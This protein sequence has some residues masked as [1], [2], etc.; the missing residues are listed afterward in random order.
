MLYR[1]SPAFFVARTRG[2]TLIEVLVALV[3]LSIGVIGLAALQAQALQLN[4]GAYMRAQATNLAY[5]IAD[6]MRT[7]REVALDGAY[8]TD[9]QPPP[10][11]EAPEAGGDLA[12]ADLAQWRMALACALPEG[13]G[14]IERDG[15]VFTITIR[16]DNRRLA[17]DGEDPIEVFVTRTGI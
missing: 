11:C 17:E 2:V 14:R 15:D 12:S 9:F 10:V 5:D 4:Q 7:N 6:R 8:D 13:Q 3:V 16:W 1:S